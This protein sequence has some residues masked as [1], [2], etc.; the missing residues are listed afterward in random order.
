LVEFFNKGFA[1]NLGGLRYGRILIGIELDLLT[2]LER[3][4]LKTRLN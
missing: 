3:L 2:Y 4:P 1:K